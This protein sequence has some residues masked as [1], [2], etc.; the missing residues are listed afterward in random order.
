MASATQP[1]P[2][3]Q[4]T[5][6]TKNGRLHLWCVG[7]GLDIPGYAEYRRLMVARLD[8]LDALDAHKSGIQIYLQSEK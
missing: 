4:G 8:S 2:H 3:C 1:C 7:T 5:G 6:R